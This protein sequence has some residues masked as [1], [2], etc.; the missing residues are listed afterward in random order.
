MLERLL[1]QVGAGNVDK[2]LHIAAAYA[3]HKDA[4]PGLAITVMAEHDAGRESPQHMIDLMLLLKKRV[5]K[6]VT[7]EFGDV[8]SAILWWL[9]P[10]CFACKGIGQLTV[11]DAARPILD[12]A[13]CP[14][15][16]G[17]KH[18]PHLASTRG[19]A[20]SLALLDGTYDWA[21]QVSQRMPMAYDAR[22]IAEAV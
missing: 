4:L 16:L 17:S 19:Y 15:C 9:Q 8:T 13:P 5:G 11:T 3:S 14:I 10:E 1:S 2:T 20:A 18:R 21:R 7:L 12:D 22:I 6:R